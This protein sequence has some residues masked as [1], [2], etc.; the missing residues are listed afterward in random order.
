MP[1][2]TD[3]A[4]WEEAESHDPL[5]VE[6][7]Q[8]LSNNADQAYSIAEIEAY[9]LDEYAH[10]FPDRLAGDDAVVGAQAARQSIIM[11]ILQRRYWNS[12]V[13]FKYVTESDTA[14]PGVYCRWDGP[15]IQP[16]AEIDEV[17]DPD[18]DS[19]RLT[20]ESRFRSIEEELDEEIEELDDRVDWLEFR[21]REE[22]GAY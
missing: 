1:I 13:R 4:A 8:L 21:V 3:S 9:L 5:E 16:I 6:I 12:V 20:L 17:N 11:A 15:G 22:L 10:L 14:E 19:P 2:E 7:T 18:P